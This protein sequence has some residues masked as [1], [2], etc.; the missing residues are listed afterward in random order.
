MARS[1]CWV[2]GQ[3]VHESMHGQGSLG[4][5]HGSPGAQ[6]LGEVHQAQLWDC[7]WDSCIWDFLNP[8]PRP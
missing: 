2:G 8:T 1:S 7:A 5:A 6:P 4:E 3:E